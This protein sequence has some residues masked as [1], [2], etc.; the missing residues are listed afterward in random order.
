MAG[1]HMW[2]TFANLTPHMGHVYRACYCTRHA[3]AAACCRRSVAPLWR[4][5]GARSSRQK[6]GGT[7]V[8]P[9]AQ[10]SIRY[11]FI[12]RRSTVVGDGG[13]FEEERVSEGGPRRPRGEAAFFRSGG[14]ERMKSA[15]EASRLGKLPAAPWLSCESLG[16]RARAPRAAA[17]ALPR[18]SP[19]SDSGPARGSPRGFSAREMSYRSPLRSAPRGSRGG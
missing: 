16:R 13:G 10:Q 2:R 6:S 3:V 18:L 11:N 8:R 9:R 4:C 7:R 5:G 17:D 19:C 12:L 15:S 14:T 1:S